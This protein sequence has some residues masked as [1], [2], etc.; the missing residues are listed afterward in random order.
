VLVVR[1][2]L[3]VGLKARRPQKFVNSLRGIL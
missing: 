2:I 3:R 1:V